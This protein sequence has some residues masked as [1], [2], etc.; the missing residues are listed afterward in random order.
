MSCCHTENPPISL[1]P[2]P[3]HLSCSQSSLSVVTPL[4]L[5]FPICFTPFLS[6]F[7][8]ALHHL[9]LPSFS[10][11]TSSFVTQFSPSQSVSFLPLFLSHY[12]SSTFFCF[13]KKLQKSVPAVLF[14]YALSVSSLLSLSFFSLCVTLLVEFCSWSPLPLSTNEFWALY[15][16]RWCSRQAL[17]AGS[18]LNKEGKREKNK[19]R[20]LQ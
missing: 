20:V 1:A 15:S 18:W 8:S 17:A 11:C 5:V 12:F 13:I 19:D 3:H 7:S 4:C 16:H 14:A 2:L 6:F 10:Q 9:S